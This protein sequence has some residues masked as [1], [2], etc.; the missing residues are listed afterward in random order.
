MD[1]DRE[2]DEYV[3]ARALVMRRTAYLLCGDWHRAEDLVQTALTKLYVAWPRVRRDGSVDA[4]ARKVLVRAS[5]DDSRRAFRRRETVVDAV[6]D[7]AVAGAGS[8][9]DVRGALASLPVGQRTVVVLRYWEDLSVTETARLIGRTEGTVKSQAAKG[10]A[11]LRELLGHDVL[12]E[13]R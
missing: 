9:L 5:I 7:T 2:F 11:A 13:Q 1:R 3:D 6:P 8:D 10:L 12:E 4:Y